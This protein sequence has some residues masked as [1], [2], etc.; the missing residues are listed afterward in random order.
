MQISHF[1]L[2]HLL[3][4]EQA[5]VYPQ[6]GTRGGCQKN[7]QLGKPQIAREFSDLH[8]LAATVLS[9]S[10]FNLITFHNPILDLNSDL[11]PKLYFE[12]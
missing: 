3:R 1:L 4:F 6:D 9:L 2:S 11:T 10:V 5:S 12:I 7:G 8:I